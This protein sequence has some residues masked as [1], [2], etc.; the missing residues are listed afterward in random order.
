MPIRDVIRRK[1]GL[2]I[3]HRSAALVAYAALSCALD[4][5][6]LERSRTRRINDRLLAGIDTCLGDHGTDRG[7][8]LLDDD[9]IYTARNCNVIDQSPK[10]LLTEPF[11]LGHI[12]TDIA[13]I[14]P[15]AA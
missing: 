1:I 12:Y 2:S 8:E 4:A 14:E 11:A 6:Q 9:T 10:R 15:Q 7:R 13:V 5:A 3:P